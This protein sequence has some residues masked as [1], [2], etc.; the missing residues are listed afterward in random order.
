[1]KIPAQI[2]PPLAT[3]FVLS[4][5]LAAC[6]RPGRNREAWEA[7]RPVVIHGEGEFISLNLQYAVPL[8]VTA[9]SGGGAALLLRDGDWV[10]N[11]DFAL[12]Y[13]TS[14]GTSLNLSGKDGL[15]YLDHRVVSLMLEKGDKD[16]A[17]ADWLAHASDAD[18]ASLRILHL[19]DEITPSALG[20]LQRVARVNPG[21]A[22]AAD[23]PPA[24]RHAL[25]LFRPQMLYARDLD[26]A[27][28]ELLR[29]QKQLEILWLDTSSVPFDFAQDLP[30]LRRLSLSQ[31]NMPNPGGRLHLL[32]QLRSL[33]L[34]GTDLGALE[35][36]GGLPP[37]LDE[38]TIKIGPRET[39]LG[40]LHGL[41]HLKFLNLIQDSSGTGLPELAELH[42]LQSVVIPPS[43][44][45]E[46][47]VRFV[48]AHPA[49]HFLTFAPDTKVVSL[50]PL[51]SLPH[52]EGLTFLSAQHPTGALFKSPA[53]LE[54]LRSLKSLRYLGLGELEHPAQLADLR[55]SLPDT[56]VVE[57]KPLCLGSGWIL[58]LLPVALLASVR[59]ARRRPDV[60]HGRA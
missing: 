44:T 15:G 28:A 29:S 55:K 58:L 20:V 25:E 52:L 41:S 30:R 3:A 51:Q 45:Q 57:V 38:L 16:A 2:F 35:K 47:F 14:D 46:Q 18:L 40:G 23:G 4:L 34:P 7:P 36:L 12:S 56:A 60:V 1:M 54:V 43:A 27:G 53:N 33:S 21:L 50:A 22:I 48:A 31:G 42:D 49:L 6:S 13:R 19:P 9:T 17:C 59:F 10:V 24:L 37:K 32:P 8:V 11:D 26:E 5:F 39:R